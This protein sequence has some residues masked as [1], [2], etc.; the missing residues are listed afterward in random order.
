M[1]TLFHFLINK[2]V[3]RVI[4]VE[5]VKWRKKDS[6]RNFS[7]IDQKLLDS[8]S[9]NHHKTENLRSLALNIPKT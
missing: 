1:E 6:L 9:R 4:H 3:A 7:R 2:F 8:C 5:Y